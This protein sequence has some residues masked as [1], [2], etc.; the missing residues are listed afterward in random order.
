MMTGNQPRILIVD[1]EPDSIRLL[2]AF[3]RDRYP[4]VMVA[5][6]GFD[7]LEKAAK[8]MPDLILLDMSMPGLSG[9]DVCRRLKVDPRLAPIPVIFLTALNSIENKLAAFDAGGVDYVTKPFSEREVLARIAVHTS[10]LRL[11]G[12]REAGGGRSPEA[13]PGGSR[14]Q[15]DE[16]LLRHACEHLA[17]HLS[18]PP[19]LAELAAI[20]KASP[21][22]LDAVFQKQLG[23][24]VFEYALELRLKRARHLLRDTDMQVQQIAWAVGYANPGDLSRAFSKRFGMSPRRFRSEPDGVA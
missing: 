2:V 6:D 4:D 11:P 14:G 21:A 23:V 16:T 3:L 13:D 17:S 12:G 7:G 22:K 18:S 5:R 10:P 8:G 1:D 24:S 15:R 9:L 20:V 19:S